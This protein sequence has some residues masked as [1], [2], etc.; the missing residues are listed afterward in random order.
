MSSK[1]EDE[2]VGQVRQ[3]LDQHADAVDELTVKQ[4]S[5]AR[6]HALAQQQPSR[7][8]WMPLAGLATAAAVALVSFMLV[9]QPKVQ[10]LG[11]DLWVAS[12]DLELIEEL[13]FY[14]WLEETQSNS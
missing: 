6:R 4:L 9:Q 10:D 8:I 7:R 13:D 12:E 11:P 2:F 1:T 5:A 14:A 3:Q